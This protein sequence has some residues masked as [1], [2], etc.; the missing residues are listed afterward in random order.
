MTLPSHQH[1]KEKHEGVADVVE[2]AAV[3][4]VVR[5]LVPEVREEDD[6]QHRIDED[7]EHQQRDHLATGGGLAVWHHEGRRPK[8]LVRGPAAPAWKA[9]A[10][11]LPNEL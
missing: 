10:P 1:L 9:R 8:D 4:V 3:G 11:C 2:I 5:V 7:D 6:A